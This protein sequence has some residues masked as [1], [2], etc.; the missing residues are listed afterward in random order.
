MPLSQDFTEKLALLVVTA[1]ISGFMIP[2]VLKVVEQRKTLEQKSK[3]AL[4][5]RQEKF[6][7]AQSAFLDTVEELL[8]QWRYLCIRVTYY[9]QPEAE[10][11][12]RREYDERLWTLL[13]GVRVQ[14]SKARR[15]VSEDCYSRLLMFYGE[16]VELDKQLQRAANTNDAER[17]FEYAKLN[18]VIYND[19]SRQIDGVLND[20]AQ[21]VSLH[22][23]ELNKTKSL[24]HAY[25]H[26]RQP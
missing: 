17:P 15:L 16:M 24:G 26:T 3:E 5:S 18:C 22:T 10:T 7:A 11:A 19:I 4:L 12:A 1:A 21:A 14:I 23:T 13:H 2:L 6:L 20:L 25:A 8:W 9:T